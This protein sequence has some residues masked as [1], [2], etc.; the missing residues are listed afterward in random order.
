M[1]DLAVMSELAGKLATADEE[2]P[3]RE[4]NDPLH[5]GGHLG[6]TTLPWGQ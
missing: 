1:A 5:H 6:R 4:L 3:A 2:G